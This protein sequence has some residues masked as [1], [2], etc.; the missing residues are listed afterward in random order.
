VRALRIEKTDHESVVE[1]AIIGEVDLDNAAELADRAIEAL[2]ADTTSL[3]VLDLGGVAFM[4]STGL[5]ALV[6]IHNVALD[7]NK[8]MRLANVPERVQKLLEI[9][10]LDT[11]LD[12]T[13]ATA[14]EDT[15]AEAD[16]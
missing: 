7:Q 2:H 14:D 6:R 13:S 15:E 1:L 3:L 5:G 4:D 12:P 11:F 16:G 9:T 10:G 8:Q